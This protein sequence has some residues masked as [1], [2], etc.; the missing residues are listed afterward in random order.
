MRRS[1]TG[2][3]VG[4][5]LA[6]GALYLAARDG[7][8]APRV[9]GTGRLETRTVSAGEVDVKIEP[10]RLDRSGAA[11]KITLDTHAVELSADLT[12]AR[13]EVGGTNWPVIGWSGDGPGGH[14]REGELRFD[15]AGPVGGTA[16]LTVPQLPAPVEASWE[17]GT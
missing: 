14:H 8:R 16:T 13:L 12:L 2:A 4:V 17:L 11:F 15:A 6:A 10:R 7:D 9:D 5:V 3:A 1:L